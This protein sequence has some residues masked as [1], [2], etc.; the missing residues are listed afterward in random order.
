MEEAKINYLYAAIAMK[1]GRFKF[2][3]ALLTYLQIYG[4][5]AEA[6]FI[7]RAEVQ[8]RWKKDEAKKPQPSSD[9]S[10]E[11]T[12]KGN[13][14]TVFWTSLEKKGETE[15]DT[16]AA[17]I[18][19]S[20]PERV[21]AERACLNTHQNMSGCIAGKYG[22]LTSPISSLGFAAQ[23][24]VEAAINDDCDQQQGQCLGSSVSEVKCLES[25]PTA[26]PDA[27]KDPKDKKDKK[28]K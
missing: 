10:A 23:K 3:L 6:E 24:A 26:A 9:S 27:G 1:K 17:V 13:E 18:R 16:K 12:D 28:K 15:D 20:L 2:L 5:P 4:L 8:Y 25:V 11:T 19:A 21:N 7:C 14:F 22:A